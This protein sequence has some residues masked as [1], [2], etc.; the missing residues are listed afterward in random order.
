MKLL[1]VYKIDDER[2]IFIW[3]KDGRIVYPSLCKLGMVDD[4]YGTMQ[5]GVKESSGHLW[6]CDMY[7]HETDIIS[8]VVT[9]V[10]EDIYMVMVN[11]KKSLY[12]SIQEG[13]YGHVLKWMSRDLVSELLKD[14]GPLGIMNYL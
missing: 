4:Q 5:F 14:I 13:L 1:D 3:T 12:Y 10:Y 2:C 9:N 7:N 11:G 8:A 6:S